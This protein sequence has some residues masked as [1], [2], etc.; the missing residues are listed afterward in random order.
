MSILLSRQEIQEQMGV[1]FSD[2]IKR[3][4]EFSV[5]VPSTA[6]HEEAS[7]TMLKI[8]K[9]F[10]VSLPPSFV[11]TAM[12]WDLG[13]L[14]LGC[15]NFAEDGNYAGRI[16][17]LNAA[18]PGCE[19]WGD[20]D[21]WETRPSDL[22]AISHGDPFMILLNLETGAIHG[23]AV[24][25]GSIN[26]RLVAPQLDMFL[27]AAGTT[28]LTHKK[29]SNREAFVGDLVAELAAAESKPFWEELAMM[30]EER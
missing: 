26:T 27:R 7:Q 3:F 20:R 19:W 14:V 6:V 2:D 8:E 17:K 24:D 9:E 1:K 15:F 11:D 25:E 4:P 29:P 16:S 13:R 28:L 22:L 18:T 21:D 10:S 5:Y 12:E 23:H 30:A